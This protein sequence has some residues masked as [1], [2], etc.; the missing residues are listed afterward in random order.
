VE[1]SDARL[2][3]AATSPIW[4]PILYSENRMRCGAVQVRPLALGSH[5]RASPPL[6]KLQL[7]SIDRLIFPHFFVG[8]P[9]GRS[10]AL[11]RAIV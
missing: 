1:Q 11:R 8:G 9:D 5:E 7:V 6:L 3:V 2:S 10:H 4:I